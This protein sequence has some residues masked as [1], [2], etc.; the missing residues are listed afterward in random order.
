MTAKETTEFEWLNSGV[1]TEFKW[2]DVK[3]SIIRF[4]EKSNSDSQFVMMTTRHRIVN[5]NSINLIRA[6]EK[7]SLIPFWFLPAQEISDSD[8]MKIKELLNSEFAIKPCTVIQS[9]G[10]LNE[11]L[12]KTPDQEILEQLGKRDYILRYTIS[13]PDYRILKIYQSKEYCEN[14]TST[15]WEN[16]R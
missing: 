5:P 4:L 1:D 13:M 2:N 3:V 7:K 11:I 6:Q 15:D 9:D 14:Q 12:P 10:I 8:V 16:S